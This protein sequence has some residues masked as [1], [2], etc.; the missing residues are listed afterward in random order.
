MQGRQSP[1]VGL[2]GTLLRA[3]SESHFPRG[4]FFGLCY[5]QKDCLPLKLKHNAVSVLARQS[6]HRLVSVLHLRPFCLFSSG[7]E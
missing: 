7:R 3:V 5:P 4:V 1:R 6:K 2:P